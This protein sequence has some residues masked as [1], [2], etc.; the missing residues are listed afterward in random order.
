MAGDIEIELIGDWSKFIKAMSVD[1]LE[2]RLDRQLLVAN[3]RIGRQFVGNAKRRIRA[4]RYA[5]NSPI[6]TIIKG[7]SKPLVDRGDLIQSITFKASPRLLLVG[8]IRAKSGDEKVNIGRTLHEGAT[9]DVGKNPKQRAAVWAKVREAVSATRLLALTGKRRELVVSATRAISLRGRKGTPMTDRQRRA[10]FARQPKTAGRTGKS[11]W[12]IPARPFI[13][14][15]LSEPV[16]IEFVKKTW[17]S[18]IQIALN[19]GK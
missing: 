19:P 12:R 17:I 3:K 15:P 4:G 7:S 14:D 9:I 1:K 16:F 5:P 2:Q 13:T 10:W 11:I 18:A 8:I 6:T